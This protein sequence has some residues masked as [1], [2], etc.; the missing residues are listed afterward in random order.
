MCMYIYMCVY[1]TVYVRVCEQTGAYTLM[2]IYMK[3]INL[4]IHLKTK[5][6][7]QTTTKYACHTETENND[8]PYI[9][10]YTE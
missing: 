7:I 4:R 9:C 6:Q 8:T 5:V 1:M 10:T 2:S 3:M